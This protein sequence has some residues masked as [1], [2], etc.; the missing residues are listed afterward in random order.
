M[1]N[2][3][4]LRNFCLSL[5]KVT[6]DVKWGNDLCFLIGGK[7]FCVTG[8]G[9]ELTAS[10]KCDEEDFNELCEREGIIP[11]PYLARNK[12]VYV[13]RASAFSKNEWEHYIQKSY[14]LVAAKL[15]KKLQKEL[16]L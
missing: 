12:W 11:A 9:G 5:P 13:Q 10:F 2:I 4:W 3:E 8:T 7:M 14:K 6:E 15:P 16:G 1:M